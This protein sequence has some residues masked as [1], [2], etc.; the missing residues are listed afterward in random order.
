MILNRTDLRIY[1]QF[2]LEL[3]REHSSSDSIEI[4]VRRLRGLSWWQAALAQRIE[5][6]ARLFRTYTSVLLGQLDDRI[7][8]RLQ[9][10]RDAWREQERQEEQRRAAGLPPTRS[11]FLPGSRADSV[12][13]LKGIVAGARRLTICDPYF[14]AASGGQE[15]SLLT[16]LRQLLPLKTLQSLYVIYSSAFNQI[17]KDG[18]Q[19]LCAQNKILLRLSRDSSF[20]DRVWIIDDRRGYLVGTSFGGIGKKLSFILDLPREDLQELWKYLESMEVESKQ[21]GKSTPVALEGSPNPG[22]AADD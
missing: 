7:N 13:T 1:L 12:R 5:S 2:L 22:P 3:E 16:D 20:H 6:D 15:Q 8:E 11:L 17:L 18:L 14:L 19:E 9:K 21:V 4:D 10:I